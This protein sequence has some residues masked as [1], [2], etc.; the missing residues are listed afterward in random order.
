MGPQPFQT[1]HRSSPQILEI[2]S[3][4]INFQISDFEPSLDMSLICFGM[5]SVTTCE[6]IRLQL[7]CGP[8]SGPSS[9]RVRLVS[10][11]KILRQ[12]ER[13]NIPRFHH[14]GFTESVFL[15]HQRVLYPKQL[16]RN[17]R[18]HAE[19]LYQPS[20]S[21]IVRHFSAMFRSRRLV[22]N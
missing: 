6:Y 10:G 5:V 12:R 15:F 20:M 8:S 22:N 16:G 9:C 17:Q 18:R 3:N 1:V 19:S 4:W 2:Q 7:T 11:Q 21:S 14:A 13:H